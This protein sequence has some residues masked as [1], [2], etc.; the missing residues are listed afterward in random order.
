MIPRV[1]WR[2]AGALFLAVALAFI[3]TPRAWAEEEASD[4]QDEQ[5]ASEVDVDADEEGAGGGEKDDGM[6]EAER[7]MLRQQRE[8]QRAR[9]HAAKRVVGFENAWTWDF[10]YEIGMGLL[11]RGTENM[12]FSR[13]RTG[14]T[15][16]GQR[17]GAII[18]IVG[19]LEHGGPRAGS[20][21]IGLQYENFSFLNSAW[22][23]VAALREREGQIRLIGSL[24]F[25]I[26][27]VDFQY[28]PGAPSGARWG[29]FAKIR[30]PISWV[31]L[32]FEGHPSASD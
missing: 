11:W 27:G 4:D 29:G 24:G 16:V 30:L 7:E 12:L 17:S 25:R 8:R 3:A 18:G 6:T 1:E 31:A 9:A 26:F 5:E 13:V 10:N 2:N 21:A 28:R 14:L 22:T 23:Q 19:E 15:R 20:P 32:A